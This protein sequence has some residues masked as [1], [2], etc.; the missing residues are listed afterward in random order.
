MDAH[1]SSLKEFAVELAMGAGEILKKGFGTTYSITSK[2]GRHDLLTEYDLKSEQYLIEAIQKKYPNHAIL[3]EEKG[4]TYETTDQILWILDP[5][6]GTVNFAHQI[7]IFC[8]SIAATLNDQPLCGVIYNPITNELF[9]AAKGEKAFFHDEPIS[10]SKVSR[11]DQAMFATGFP[12]NVAENPNHCI[13]HL[14]HI[15]RQGSPI[16]RMG[17]AALDLAYLAAGR[18]DAFWEVI[19]NPWD[20]AAGSLIVEEAGGTITQMDNQPITFTK[21]IPIAGSNGLLHN[22]VIQ[23]LEVI[24]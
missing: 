23:H 16:R 8:I 22:D 4:G 24:D 6:D 15:L 10:V 20:F 9:H 18:V 3:S 17:S 12:Y 19:L 21:R 13:E 14:T 11:F 2:D 1:P 7:P 5:I